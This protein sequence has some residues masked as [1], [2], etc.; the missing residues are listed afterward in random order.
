MPSATDRLV[1]QVLLAADLVP[2][3]RVVSYGDLAALVGTSP[4]RV[5][6]IMA[7]HGHRTNW[8]RVTNAAGDLVVLDAARAMWAAEGIRIK[9]NG[10]GT[11]MRDHHADLARLAAD[12]E[13]AGG[14]VVDPPAGQP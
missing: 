14:V 5:G 3:G 11:R 10:L 2:S 8:W 4:R 1:E 13:A 12:F 7:T 9:P 6:R